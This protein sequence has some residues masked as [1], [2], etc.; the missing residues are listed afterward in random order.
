MASSIAWLTGF[1]LLMNINGCLASTNGEFDM[2]K[3]NLTYLPGLQAGVHV[4]LQGEWNGV[5]LTSLTSLVEISLLALKEM[6]AYQTARWIESS[7]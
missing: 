4:G 5:V 2:D 1:W 3:F 6:R 7:F